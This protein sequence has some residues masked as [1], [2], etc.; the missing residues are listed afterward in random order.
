MTF[1]LRK[2]ENVV[3]VYENGELV[4]KYLFNNRKQFK[5]YFYPLNAP[6]GLCVTED[7]PED[8]VHHRS[9]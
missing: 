9:M 6:G 7:G 8:H 5:P 1:E 2:I 3:E 4:S